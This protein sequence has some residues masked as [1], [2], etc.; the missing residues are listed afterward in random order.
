MEIKTKYTNNE[1]D[2]TSKKEYINENI[3]LPY[4]QMAAQ[5]A[6]TPIS[7]S[8]SSILM[9]LEMEMSLKILKIWEIDKYNL[10]ANYI[11]N[12]IIF[13]E[14]EKFIYKTLL[15]KILRLMPGGVTIISIGINGSLAKRFTQ[16]LGYAISELISSYIKSVNDND[17]NL[18]DFFTKES[19]EDLMDNYL[20]EYNKTVLN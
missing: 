13:V 8:D 14:K 17:V 6:S 7:M 18:K 12:D 11:L 3:L 5:K 10:D 16:A 19:L 1:L 9:D 20:I 15:G 2:F 4:G